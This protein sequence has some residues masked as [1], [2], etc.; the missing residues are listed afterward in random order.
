[1]RTLLRRSSYV[2]LILLAASAGTT[3]QQSLSGPIVTPPFERYLELLRQQA[4]IPGLSAAILKDGQIVWE[5]GF[6]YQNL[7]TR[8]V[9][10]PDT[11]YLVGDISQTL[12]TVLLLQCVEERHL[13]LDAPLT[14]YGVR[15]PEAD[16]SLR[17]VLSH[18]SAL[19]VPAFKYDPERFTQLT[20]VMESCA[21][22]PYRK[23][24]SHRILERLAMKD[25]VPGRDLR[26]ASVVPD[27]LYEPAALERYAAILD[28]MAIP[29]RLDKKGK[30]VRSEPLPAAGITAADGLVSTVRDLARFDAAIDDFILLREETLAVAWSNATGR[31]GTPVPA[32]LG[33]FVQGYE[34]EPVVWHFGLVPGSYSSLILKLPARRVTLILLANSDG[35]SAAFQ[36]PLGDVTRSLFA[37][38]FLKL[39]G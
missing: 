13:D 29:Y 5:R 15:L 26:D 36:L 9:A 14:R 30:P 16:A 4:G 39:I 18:T 10:T 38:T 23:S 2:G 28:R 7:E 3:A 24:V 6:G 21:P 27:W 11:P 1:V 20:A 33:W 34:G 22:Q 37:T 19:G 25:S 35:L 17:R 31:D 12:A 8:V 32:G